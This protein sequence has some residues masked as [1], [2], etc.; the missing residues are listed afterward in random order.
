MIPHSNQTI[1]VPPGFTI[2]EQLNNRQMS[3]KEFAVR[4]DMS[5]KHISHLITGKVELTFDVAQRL[6]SVLGVPARIWSEL[7]LRYQERLA[8]VRRELSDESE[9]KLAQKFPYKEM[10]ERG[11]VENTDDQARR[12]K[13]LRSFFE[14]ANLDALYTLGT[15]KATDDEQTLFDVAQ[16]QFLKIEQRKNAITNSD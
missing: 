4:M 9:A 1:A 8:Q 6:E 7:E 14:V 12:L 10:A 11:W 2:K 13:N 16:K 3:Q 5:E 15:L